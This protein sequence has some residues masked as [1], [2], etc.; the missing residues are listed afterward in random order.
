MFKNI[1]RFTNK[2]LRIDKYLR[3]PRIIYYRMFGMD[4]KFNSYISKGYINNPSCV[5]IGEFTMIKS[6]F[7]IGYYGTDLC[8][9][10]H[11][12][13]IGNRVFVGND[14]SFDITSGITINDDCMIAQGCKFIDHNHGSALGTLMKFQEG[15][16][17]PIIIGSDVW[18]GCNVIVLKGV[19]I[20]E[21][22]VVGAGS[23]VT[24]SIPPFEIW[25]GVPARFLRKRT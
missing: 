13:S 16:S 3:V 9:Y 17:A 1:N 24:K 4:I 5:S 21:G 25:G 18:L 12:I 14:S 6:N 7:N 15:F 2:Y 11:P 19:I 20:S 22:S 8:D 10:S 23:V